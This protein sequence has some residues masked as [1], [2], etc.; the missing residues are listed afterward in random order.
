MKI[1]SLDTYPNF[2]NFLKKDDNGREINIYNFRDIVLFGENLFYPNVRFASVKEKYVDKAYNPVKE[3]TM[4]LKKINS[5]QYV[6]SSSL[7]L[8][9]TEVDTDYNFFFVYNTDNYY[10][11]VYDTLPY[12]ITYLHLKTNYPNLKLLMNYP[13][14]DKKEIYK[15]VSEFLEI[16]NINKNDIKII[17]KN[18]KYENIFVSTSYTHDIDSN[19]PPR[20]EIYDFY[21]KLVK[22]TGKEYPKKIYISR[23]SWIHGD[24]SNIGTNY[25]TRRKLT[26]ED[27]LVDFLIKNGYEEVFTENFSTQEKLELFSQA[28]SVVGS[29]GGGLCNVLFSNKNCNLISIISPHFLEINKR[30]EYS[31]CGVNYIPFLDTENT[32]KGEFKTNM[33]VKCGDVVGEIIAIDSDNI[34]ISYSDVTVSGWN[35]ESKFKENT[36]KSSEC[37]KLDEGLNSP[38]KMN[39]DSFNNYIL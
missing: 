16:L 1:E 39:L 17:Q 13:N 20:K 27:E 5:S 3:S 32:E 25:T 30:F 29:I 21:K 4:S 9:Y 6:D 12:L 33:R 8:S 10:H 38:W 24:F 14:S 19:L 34:I 37:V 31:F 22:T 11:F 18:T 15:F 28:E 26:N 35:N 36:V 2:K 23:R 7:D